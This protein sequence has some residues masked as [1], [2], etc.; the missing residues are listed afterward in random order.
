MFSTV[1]P[2]IIIN[3]VEIKEEK[4]RTFLSS[5]DEHSAVHSLDSDEVLGAL[6]VFVLVSEAY[7]SKRSTSAGV[8]NNV[9][10]NTL[11]VTIEKVR[12]DFLARLHQSGKTRT[13]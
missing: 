5:V 2:A 6:F 11:N 3:K 13:C 7:L 4:R 9:S 12:V 1:S 10:D 8:V